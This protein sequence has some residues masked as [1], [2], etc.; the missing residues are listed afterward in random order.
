MRGL[1]DGLAQ[2][3]GEGNGFR[4]PNYTTDTNDWP[5][6][7][8]KGFAKWFEAKMKAVAMPRLREF[9]HA[10]TYATVDDVP[11]YEWK[12]PLQQV[13]Q[14]LKRHRDVMFKDKPELKPISMII[15][16]LSAHGYEGEARVYDALVNIVDRMPQ[17]V[18]R[19]MPRVPNPV[20]PAEDFADAWTRDERLAKNFWAWHQQA[21]ADSASLARRLDAAGLQDLLK[22]KF[23]AQMSAEQ[24]RT[25]A[26]DGGLTALATAP[27][28]AIKTPPKPWGP[29]A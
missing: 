3:V 7:N 2:P 28:V 26:G 5:R 8:P 9:V 19:Q 12:T 1:L 23:G 18:R 27:V 13:I 10:R 21:Q 20:N 22:R 4:D 14:I 6:S 24:A 11:T 29:H 16:T 15:T 17:F 25:A